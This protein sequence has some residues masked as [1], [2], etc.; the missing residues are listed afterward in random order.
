MAETAQTNNKTRYALIIIG[1]CLLNIITYFTSTAVSLF[2]NPVCGD[3]GFNAAALKVYYT[4]S[5]FAGLLTCPFIMKS[6]FP[7]MGARKMILSLGTVGGIAYLAM[8]FCNQLWQWY[9]LAVIVGL[10]LSSVIGTLANILINMWFLDKTGTVLGVATAMTGVAGIVFS[11]PLGAIVSNNWRS[12]YFFVGGII[13]AI[14]WISGLLCIR[15]SPQE[16]G[17]A[18]YGLEKYMEKQ[19]AAA[20]QKV[21][22]KGMTMSNA[23]KTASF[24]LFF[25]G[26]VV[27]GFLPAFTQSSVGFFMEQGF[28]LTEAA[29]FLAWMS[30]ALI[31][32]KLALGWL[33]D[34]VGGKNAFLIALVISFV[35][36]ALQ[37]LVGA[38][39][40]V[41]PYVFIICYACAIS[42]ISVL[43]T[44]C[45]RDMFGTL[46]LQGILPVVGISAGVSNAV[47]VMLWEVLYNVTG[48]YTLCAMLAAA[49][50][51]IFA[52]F[53]IFAYKGTKAEK[54]QALIEE[55]EAA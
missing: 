37:L 51:V 14:I 38:S 41:V 40:S 46:D 2:Y 26:N 13:L 22:L 39:S 34:K 20:G 54:F 49:S 15:N 12:G 50:I 11:S 19:Q 21:V 43:N 53:I 32:W 44:V 25:I 42:T 28:E 9:V 24:W 52:V 45:I 3:L 55:K 29:G 1:T 4:I 36:F 35:G 16:C 48:S 23:M 18:P 17:I 8:G 47:C 27:F 7:K 33:A 10:C 5:M 31:V 30:G 6:L